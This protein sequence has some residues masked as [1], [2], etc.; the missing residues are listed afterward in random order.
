MRNARL[1]RICKFIKQPE[2]VLE[3]T[4]RQPSGRH[5]IGK[6]RTDMSPAVQ[7][8]FDNVVSEAH[9]GRWQ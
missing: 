9:V 3:P 5:Q 1:V 2:P 4:G 7:A 8:I 6:W